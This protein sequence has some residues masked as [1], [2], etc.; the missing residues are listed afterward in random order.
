VKGDRPLYTMARD[1]IKSAERTL[2]VFE[3]FARI[4]RAASVQELADKL[5]YPRSSAAALVA[6]LVGLGYL[7]HDRAARKYMPT[8]RIA[9]LGAWVRQAT[10]GEDRDRIVPLLH[11]LSRKV[12]ETV[13]L[14]VAQD[15]NVQYVHVELPERPLMYFQKAGTLRPLCRTATGW[16]LLSGLP[17]TEVERALER[18]NAL[19]A[20]KPVDVAEIRR[21]VAAARK[22]GYAFSRQAFLP[23]IGMIAMPMTGGDARRY[24]VGVGGPVER[25]EKKEKAIVGEMRACVRTFERGAR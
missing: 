1:T 4:E 12:D 2:R 22:R 25:L 13:V 9:E 11:A 24:A 17:E 23:G 18:H 19:G 20:D 8:A 16:A 21:E 15:L 10:L 14:G 6:S 5:G 3:Y 7:S